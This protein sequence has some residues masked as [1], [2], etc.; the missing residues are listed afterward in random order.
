MAI[1]NYPVIDDHRQAHQSL[2][3]RLGQMRA[4]LTCSNYDNLKVA[5]FLYRWAE[6]HRLTFDKD[7]ADYYQD[8]QPKTANSG[9]S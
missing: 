6:D 4:D 5:D 3:D 8:H 7:F 2:L 1:A 9:S